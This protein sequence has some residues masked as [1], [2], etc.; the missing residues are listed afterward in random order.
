M[1]RNWQWEWDG[2]KPDWSHR[3]GHGGPSPEQWRGI[4][5]FMR[6]MF[7]FMFLLMVA[8]V[9][10]VIW[11]LF[12]LASAAVVW[13]IASPFILAL[14]ALLI[15]RSFFRT[16][17][18]VRSLVGMAGSLADGDYSARAS[19]PRS[20]AIRPVVRSF[21]R[22]AERLEDAD[23]QRRQ[24]LADLGHEIRTPLTIVRGEIEAMIDG[25]HDPDPDHLEGLLD[26]VR[27]MERLVEDLRTLSLAE[28]GALSLHPEPT[29][30]S[31]LVGDVVDSLRR[32][33][34]RSAVVV[35]FSPD[36]SLGE[37][38]VDPVRIREV[39]ANLIVNSLRAMPEGGAL[40]VRVDGSARD[41]VKIVVKDTGIGI[42]AD[43]IEHVFDRFHKSDVSAGSGLGLTISRDLVAGHG[44]TI[45]MASDVGS[46]TTVTVTLPT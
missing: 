40:T 29:D 1:P 6:V 21:N 9:G 45:A 36:P 32:T 11:L 10:F 15:L 12:R 2:S 44:G 43:E 23:E 17:R 26:E 25:V 3:G 41:S 30:L 37:V 28:A 13:V 27:V 35:R 18:P 39:V 42:P 33:A 5:R 8:S 46:G 34:E 7:F 4:R 22:L 31:D 14:V 20:G 19:V 24:L 38:L 16:W